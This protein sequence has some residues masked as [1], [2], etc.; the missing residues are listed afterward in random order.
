MRRARTAGRWLAAV[1]GITLSLSGAYLAYY[2]VKELLDPIA[3]SP[4]T[5][6]VTG[7]Q[8]W[9]AAGIAAQPLLWAILLGAVVLAAIVV[10]IYKIIT[11]TPDSAPGRRERQDT[12]REHH[13]V[14]P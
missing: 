4:V 14:N 12:A 1:S 5:S 8:D 9:F 2:W 7:V 10:V 11:E 3:V 13:T 6:T